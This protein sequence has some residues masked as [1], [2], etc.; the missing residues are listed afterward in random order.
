MLRMLLVSIA[1][2]AASAALQGQAPGGQT[3]ISAK[4]ALALAPLSKA[5]RSPVHTDALEAAIVAGKWA[6]PKAGDSV[7][8]P[9]GRMVEWKKLSAAKEGTFRHGNGGYLFFNV[10]S[11]QQRIMILEASGHSLVYVNGEPRT[12]DGYSNGIVKV[13]VLLEK[14]ENSFLFQVARGQLQ[15][16]LAEPP[17]SLYLIDNDVLLPDVLRDENG[18]LWAGVTAVNA[19]KELRGREELRVSD[20]DR[21]KSLDPPARASR[22]LLPLSSQKIPVRLTG[23][24]AGKAAK[25]RVQF[26]FGSGGELASRLEK[27]LNI[28]TKEQAHIRTFESGIDGSVQYYAVQPANRPGASALFLSLH[29]AS[30]EARGQAAAY[31]S[32]AWG[33]IIAPTNRRPYGFDWEDWGRI[34]ALEV[35]EHAQ[36]AYKTDPQRTYLTGHSMG[37]HGTWHVGVTYPDRFAAIG[38]SAGWVS[39][40]TY[41]GGKRPAETDAVQALMRRATNPSDT[42]ALS[43]NYLHQG[44]YV[45]HGDA[46]DNVPVSQARTMK[47]HLEPFHHD[48]HYFEQPKAGHWWSN[49]DEPGAACV[50]WAPMFDL[51]ARRTIP[52][53]NEIRE[54]GFVTANPGISSKCHWLAIEAQTKLLDFSSVQIRLDP[55]KRRFVGTTTNVARLKLDL[56]QLEAGK[57]I[58]V[59]LDGHKLPPVP[60]PAS[61]ALWLTATGKQWTAT[62][63]PPAASA[64]GPH[65]YGPF[66]EAFQNRM[67]FVFGTKGTPAENA[68]AL[69]KAR[70]DAETFWYRGNGAIEV[71]PDAMF[72][73]A[74]GPDRSIILYGNAETNSAWPVL[75]ANSPV[76]VARG[77]VTIDGRQEKGDDL[78]CLFLR[79]RPGSDS[80]CVGA[81]SGTGLAGMRLGDRLPIFIS[82]VAFPDCIV[83][84]PEMLEK[85]FE[86]VRAAG[87]FGLDWSVSSGEFAWRGGRP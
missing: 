70:F 80:A 73:A 53:A 2:V 81:V 76:Q 43:K 5:G 68:W 11:D 8:L 61:A 40:W 3:V 35:L 64:K 38:P 48:F 30:V 1:L 7:T 44:I 17:A 36:K 60:W 82:G 28:V 58:T 19:S 56:R 57:E 49:T 46:D 67:M 51:F 34:D 85:G 79:P 26:A 4:E 69:A 31:A 86:G 32:K 27:S 13:P 24:E 72:D 78:A 39:F 52:R 74:R 62:D 33:H 50:D 47:S 21:T 55:V 14:G 9:D 54:I 84:G 71:I 22:V 77:S 83:I 10:P 25:V 29:G 16:R 59:E 18:D 12:G 42:L 6:P 37:G 41:A 65:R 75:L 63:S 45:L 66:R 23:V 20:L 15:W 87:Y